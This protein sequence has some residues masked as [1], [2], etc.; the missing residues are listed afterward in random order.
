MSLA[1]KH[2]NNFNIYLFSILIAVTIIITLSYLPHIVLVPIFVLLYFIYRYNFIISFV[3]LAF[4]TATSFILEEMRPYLNMLLTSITGLVF[5]AYFGLNFKKYPRP[6]KIYLLFLGLLLST[7]IVATLFSKDFSVSAIASLRTAIFLLICYAFYA[8]LFKITNVYLYIYTLFITVVVL[9]VGIFLQIIEAGFTIFLIK[10]GLARFSGLYANPNYVGQVLIISV[11]FI[12]AFYFRESFRDK[13]KIF[14]LTLFL[15]LNLFLIFAIDSRASALAIFISTSF[16]LLKLNKRFYFKLVLTTALV[17]FI[18]YLIPSIQELVDMFMRIERMDTRVFF[19]EAGIDVIYDYPITG[20]GPDLFQKLI[21]N[22][23]PSEAYTYYHPDVWFETKANPH[24]FFLLMISENGLLGILTSLSLFILY[25]YLGFRAIK[26]TK[27]D[28][29]DIYLLS[30]AL[31]GIGLGIFIRAFYEVTGIMS[32]GYIT[33]D[34][35]FWLLL[36]ILMYINV[37][38]SE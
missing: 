17:F 9:S 2:N 13:I 37:K 29:Y 22:F 10:G 36:N 30:V 7:L 26:I 18:L 15:V 5:F 4:V 6:P 31:T 11:S 1:L 27:R 34:L 20:V 23:L 33:R 19:W 25:F 35:P 38:Y 21:F 32:Y 3:I 24:N 12:T 28:Y 8:F 14:W 16:I